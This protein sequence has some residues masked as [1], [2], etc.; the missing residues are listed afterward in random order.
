[1]GVNPYSFICCISTLG[2]GGIAGEDCYLLY[3]PSGRHFNTREGWYSRRGLLPPVP[4]IWSAFQ[5]K[6][7]L[8]FSFFL[9]QNK[10]FVFVSRHRS[11]SGRIVLCPF[12]TRFE[13][14]FY[15]KA[16]IQMVSNTNLNVVSV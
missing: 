15:S 6:I 11:G 14:F 5:I 16:A 7:S 3:L 8:W 10:Y 1:M 9:L 2:K 12:L 13:C 4:S